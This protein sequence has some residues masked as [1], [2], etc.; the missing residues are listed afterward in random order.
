MFIFN[1]IPLPFDESN[2]VY[3][4]LDQGR[5]NT[6]CEKI[7]P[8]RSNNEMGYDFSFLVC[9]GLFNAAADNSDY[10][11]SD[12]GSCEPN[13][14]GRR[15]RERF[16]PASSCCLVIYLDAVRKMLKT[17]IKTEGFSA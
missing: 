16:Y 9:C 4:L 5:P 15:V 7:S 10:I 1:F 17:L 3:S 6:V 12:D 14:L 13:R 8:A 2:K 11:A